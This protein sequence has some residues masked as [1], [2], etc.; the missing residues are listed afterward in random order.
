L[1]ALAIPVWEQTH[2]D[3]EALLKIGDLDRLRRSLLAL[4]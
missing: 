3:V 1:L 2:R 4:S